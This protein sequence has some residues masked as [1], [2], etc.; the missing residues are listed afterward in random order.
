VRTILN[1]VVITVAC[2]GLSSC[3]SSKTAIHVEPLTS[4]EILQRVHDRASAIR[5]M[6]ADGDLTVESPEQSGTV[7]FELFLK[8]PDTLWMKFSGPFGMSLGTLMLT[9]AEFTFYDPFQKQKIKGTTKPEILSRV[10]N[11][12]LSYIDVIDAVTGSFNRI[13][14]GDEIISNTVSEYQYVLRAIPTAGTNEHTAKKEL[15]V[16]AATFVTTKFAEYDGGNRP[17]VVGQSSRIESVDGIS[18]P[19]L[20]R[21]ILP[22]Q[23]QSVTLAYST[24]RINRTS[25][26]TFSL[27]SNVKEFSIDDGQ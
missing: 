1:A 26:K 6:E 16:D 3:V 21:V 15:W 7:S 5:T 19:H 14:V 2:A 25:E 23:R 13:A 20:V 17:R 9:P 10:V 27:P 22:A 8:L 18:M 24:L 4:E 11:V 12:S